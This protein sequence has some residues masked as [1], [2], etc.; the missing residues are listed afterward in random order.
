M[1]QPTVRQLCELF[2]Q[3]A[4]GKITAEAIQELIERASKIGF[5]QIFKNIL[6]Q[7]RKTAAE[8]SNPYWRAKALAAIAGALAKAREFESAR[9]TAAEIS[10]PY[11]RAEAL[12]AI[13]GALAKAREFESAR[14]TAAEISDSYWRAEALA[15]IAGALSE[16]MR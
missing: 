15:A 6:Q 1:S 13:A 10:D 11:V 7:A 9:K 14:K 12:A 4:E 3:I 16:A 5:A 8:I 2:G